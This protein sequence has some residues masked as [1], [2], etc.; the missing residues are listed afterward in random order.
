MRFQLTRWI[1]FYNPWGF[2]EGDLQIALEAITTPKEQYRKKTYFK[3]D[4][5]YF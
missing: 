4:Y 5:A 3:G 1:R 2:D